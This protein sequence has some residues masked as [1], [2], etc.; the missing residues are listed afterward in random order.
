MTQNNLL[1][2]DS[3]ADVSLGVLSSMLIEVRDLVVALDEVPKNS[4]QDF[5]EIERSITVMRL[6]SLLLSCS[7]W[8]ID[9][10]TQ[11]C[12]IRDGQQ[13]STSDVE[14]TLTQQFHSVSHSSCDTSS[15]IEMKVESLCRRLMQLDKSLY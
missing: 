2:S 3:G 15:E 9:R 13:I 12:A 5:G 14:I 6:N 10:I 11:I 7:A 1:L 8:L 4:S